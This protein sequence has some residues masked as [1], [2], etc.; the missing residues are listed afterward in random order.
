[1]RG[2][3]V[4]V[5]NA[6]LLACASIKSEEAMASI[7]LLLCTGAVPDTWAPNG[8]SVRCAA[9][10]SCCCLQVGWMWV[11]NSSAWSEVMKGAALP[12]RRSCWRQLW[13][14]WKPSMSC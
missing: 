6:M 12:C 8:S 10:C 13:T 1:M 14:A 9:S 4:Q 2:A 3:S 11:P 7:T 5:L